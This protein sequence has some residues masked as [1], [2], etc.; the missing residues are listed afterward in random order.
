M[1][2]QQAHH[3]APQ[4]TP[5][6]GGGFWLIVVLV[7][8]AAAGGGW[9][10][11]EHWLPSLTKLFA[12]KEAPTKPPVRVMPVVTA[13]V[14]KRDMDLYLNG[15]GTVTALKTV[16][17]RSRVEGELTKVAFTEGQFVRAGDLLAEIDPR[18]FEV[19]SSR[20]TVGSR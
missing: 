14:K 10:Y 20:W 19:R 16:T 17:I 11:R 15:L 8:S 3:A 12:A 13:T 18:P 6:A 1:P 9:F 4:P 2:E 5:G 7:I